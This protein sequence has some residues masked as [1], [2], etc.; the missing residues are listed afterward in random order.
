MKNRRQIDASDH[1]Q[2][3]I[4]YLCCCFAVSAARLML[5]IARAAEDDTDT[6]AKK[7]KR[8]ETCHT[9]NAAETVHLLC[10]VRYTL[11]YK[12]LLLDQKKL[13]SF[14]RCIKLDFLRDNVLFSYLIMP[15]LYQ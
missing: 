12:V 3:Y 15:N 10:L 7:P 5:K 11:L 13:Q 4:V 6:R 1:Q 8:A 14:L 9:C 2:C